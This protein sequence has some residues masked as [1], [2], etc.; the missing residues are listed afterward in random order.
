MANELT[1]VMSGTLVYSDAAALY[2]TIRQESIQVSPAVKGMFNKIFAIPTSDT[3]LTI[4]DI[5]TLGYAFFKNLDTTNYITLGP[6][7]GGALV[8]ML[9]LRAGYAAVIPLEPGITLR[10]QAN[11]ATVRLQVK[12]FESA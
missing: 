7:S 6:T 1:M 10:A 3:V 12:V 9:R 2:D 4:G 8:P 11:T 5:T